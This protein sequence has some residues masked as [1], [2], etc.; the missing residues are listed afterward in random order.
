MT[1][2]PTLPREPYSELDYAWARR[3][4]DA[5]VRAVR[6]RCGDDEPTR[7]R[8]AWLLRRLADQVE[9]DE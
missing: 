5:A 3:R 9:A 7:R 4:L 2:T 1:T 8:V 6:R